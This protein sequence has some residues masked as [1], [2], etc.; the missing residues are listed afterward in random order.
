MPIIEVSEDSVRVRKRASAGVW[1]LWIVAMLFC[2]V[3][4][5]ALSTAVLSFQRR[6][7]ARFYAN[8]ADN[9][10]STSNGMLDTFRS[11]VSHRLCKDSQFAF[12]KGEFREATMQADN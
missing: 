9:H 1:F 7:A 10:R 8:R 5:I 3:A 11:Q 4:G 2:E 12:K 6:F